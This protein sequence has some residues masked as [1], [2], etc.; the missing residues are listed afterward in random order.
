MLLKMKLKR[1]GKQC[2]SLISMLFHYNKKSKVLYLHDV[3]KDICYAANDHSVPIAKFLE[4]LTAVKDS[5][6]DIVQDITEAKGQVRICFDDGYRGI[7]DCKELLI[8]N[9]V[10]PTIFVATSLIGMNNYLSKEE[11]Q[12]LDKLGF[13]IQSHTVSHRP[14]TE[15]DVDV[16]NDEM[17]SSKRVLEGL[18]HKKVDEVCFPIGYYN[19]QVLKEATKYYKHL[20]ISVPGA[21]FEN[22]ENGIVHRI[23]CQ[24]MTP[25]SVKIALLGGQEVFK[26]H[27]NKLHYKPV[28]QK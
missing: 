14:L 11:I 5:G 1:I 16:L 7:W 13:S 17:S 18:I 4:L 15:F 28:C 2:L 26:N 6:F 27:I 20:F 8:D 21:Y 9:G 19:E 25:C 22:E 23:L 24:D 12:V 3:H 10:F